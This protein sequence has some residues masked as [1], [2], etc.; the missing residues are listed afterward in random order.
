M[1]KEIESLMVHWGEQ[2]A[3]HGLG[4]GIGS[5]MGS[6]MEWKGTA[7]RGTPGSRIVSGGAGMDQV[8]SEIDAVIAGLERG[9]APEQKLAKLARQRYCQ[10]VTVREQM[11]TA[12]IA[13]GA[14]RTYRNW[15]RRL[16]ERVLLDLT[17]RTRTNRGYERQGG[18]DHQ[19][20]LIR[21]NVLG[22]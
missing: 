22:R 21:T 13:E 14:D 15:V 2:L 16:H 11:Q 3:R 4:A 19:T 7:P 1:I 8:A 6:I 10:C 5:Q 20:A 9:A 18:N 17:M 12:G